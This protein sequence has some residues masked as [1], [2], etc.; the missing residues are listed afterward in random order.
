MS[1]GKRM[2]PR[3]WKTLRH[4]TIDTIGIMTERRGFAVQNLARLT[5]ITTIHI[6]YTLS[7]Y[8]VGSALSLEMRNGMG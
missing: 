8:K 7:K 5:D 3:D 6:Q 1:S 2:V 4:A